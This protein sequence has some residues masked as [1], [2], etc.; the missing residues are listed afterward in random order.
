DDLAGYIDGTCTDADKIGKA[1]KKLVL[2]INPSLYVHIKEAKNAKVWDKLKWFDDSASTATVTG[3]TW[4]RR[5]EHI[6]RRDLLKKHHGTVD[7]MSLKPKRL[8]DF[9][10]YMRGA[11]GELNQGPITV[12]EAL[13]GSECSASGDDG[14]I[15]GIQRKWSVGALRTSRKYDG[16]G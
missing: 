15:R 1:K 16:C 10:T 13:P 7:G 14:R 3:N 2:S 4:H 9:V 12:T 8:D 6:N 11:E 5:L